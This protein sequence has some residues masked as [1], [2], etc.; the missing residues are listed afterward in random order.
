MKK[1]HSE[2]AS[3]S[4]AQAHSDLL[5]F[6]RNLVAEVWRSQVSL[7]EISLGMEES[8]VFDFVFVLVPSFD[9]VRVYFIAAKHCTS[10]LAWGE[11]LKKSKLLFRNRRLR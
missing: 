6:S 4:S 11:M 7:D 9:T 10:N 1:S 8:S 3:S 5:R 2:P